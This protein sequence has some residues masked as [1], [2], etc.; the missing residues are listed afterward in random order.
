MW[1]SPT[2]VH[3]LHDSYACHILWCSVSIL[4]GISSRSNLV[5]VSNYFLLFLLS[6]LVSNFTRVV[7]MVVDNFI[8]KKK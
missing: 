5:R 7:D 3:K 6:K 8:F 2:I 1:I 4:R